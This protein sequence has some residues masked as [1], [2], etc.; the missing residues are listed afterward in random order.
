[1]ILIILI[2]ALMA[3]WPTGQKIKNEEAPPGR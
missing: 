1:L 2:G 3:L